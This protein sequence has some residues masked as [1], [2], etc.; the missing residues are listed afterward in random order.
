VRIHVNCVL[1]YKYLVS[2]D[3]YLVKI[4][5]FPAH[6]FEYCSSDLELILF[7]PLSVSF[8]SHRVHIGIGYRV[9]CIVVEPFWELSCWYCWRSIVALGN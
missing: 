9:Y 6:N 1:K 7:D 4:R 5:G 2:S 3:A 8:S